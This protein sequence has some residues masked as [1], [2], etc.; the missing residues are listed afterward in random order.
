[1]C[2]VKY[3]VFKIIV[4]CLSERSLHLNIN[5]QT[6]PLRT[7]N[8]I[9]LSITLQTYFSYSLFK[10]I[11]KLH[12]LLKFG[13]LFCYIQLVRNIRFFV[14]NEVGLYD[15]FLSSQVSQGG[16]LTPSPPYLLLTPHCNYRYKCK[17]MENSS[18]YNFKLFTLCEKKMF[19][20]FNEKYSQTLY[21]L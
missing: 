21:W 14:Y 16:G 8:P 13:E 12:L 1:M 4:L 11:S 18:L 7:H 5:W 19:S 3:W 10:L 15:F 20:I 2:W 17:G 6:R 9:R